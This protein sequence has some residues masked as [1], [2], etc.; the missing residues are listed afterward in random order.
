[1]NTSFFLGGAEGRITVPVVAY[2]VVHPNGEIAVFDTGLGPRFARPDGEFVRETVD[3]DAGDLIDARITAAGYDPAQVSIIVSSH[4]HTDHAGGNGLLPHA[5]VIVQKAEWDYAVTTD[6]PS[7]YRSEFETGQPI[8][9]ITG[10]HDVF[11]DG[12][13]VLYPT[14]GHTPGHQSGVV[15]TEHGSVV[16]TGDACNLRANLDQMRTPDHMD[17]EAAYLVALRD[18]AE[19]RAGGAQIFPSHDPEFWAGIDEAQP[20][21]GTSRS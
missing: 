5:R 6:N 16:L 7:Y 8:Q 2:L 10:E 12:S 13:F 11:G 9:L 1:M 4:L 18:F 14:P 21:K 15:E 17:D 20:W 19:R 3:L